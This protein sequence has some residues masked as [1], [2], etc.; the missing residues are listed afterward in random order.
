MGIGFFLK[1]LTEE[2]GLRGGASWS[3]A[4][5]P[6]VSGNFL[7]LGLIGME[8]LL[9]ILLSLCLIGVWF[10][11]VS[12]RS[13]LDSTLLWV[14]P[15]LLVLTR[16]EGAF[17]AFL[18]IVAGRGA[19]R[20]GR[21]R[22]VLGSG[23]ACGVFISAA[24]NWLVAH[25]LTPLTMKGRQFLT[26]PNGL[27][28][29]LH[30]LGETG[31]RVT[32]T[33][34][35]QL[36]QIFPSGWSRLFG[37]LLLFVFAG[38]IVVAISRLR[39]LPARRFL[40]LCAWAA[41]IELLYFV[42]LPTQGHGGRYIALPL[43]IFLSLIFFGLHELLA[44]IVPNERLVWLSVVIIAVG[45]TVDSISIWRKAAAADIDQINSEHGAMS[46]W[47]Q[48]NLPASNF[49]GAYVG[50]FDIGRIGFQFHGNIV[51][52]GGLVDSRYVTYLLE[53]RTVEYLRE[54]S[55]RYVVLPTAPGRTGFDRMLAL[56]REHGATLSL[57][58]TVCADLGIATLAFASS[59]TA[60]P[61]QSLYAIDYQ[62]D[63]QL[64]PQA[65]T[66]ARPR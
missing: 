60:L 65:F 59:S 15:L 53:Q 50:V 31:T 54:R 7:W 6:A 33:W 43:M 34:C 5:A 48:Q 25:Q 14:L 4:L 37:V 36:S 16:P 9:F 58:H 49:T 30:F 17:L 63:A 1:R 55:V 40:F 62:A 18:L 38:L 21:D 23:A 32:K 52:L 57:V 8:H 39:A 10:R 35:I 2:D 44:A 11:G 45:T 20:T 12:K 56:D 19:K 28:N 42:F 47:L 13:H 66:N 51:D 61:C 41:S 46:L 27:R 26:S 29:Q 24:V 3:L 64:N 22:L